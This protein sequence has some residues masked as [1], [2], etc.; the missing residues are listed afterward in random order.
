MEVNH[1]LLFHGNN[2]KELTNLLPGC[3]FLCIEMLNLDIKIEFNIMRLLT[4][5]SG[6]F[7]WY[8]IKLPGG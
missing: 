5:V 3:M 4:Y 1:W 6:V 2:K 8:G 7:S